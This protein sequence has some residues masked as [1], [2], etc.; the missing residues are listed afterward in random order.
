M[1]NTVTNEALHGS[2]LRKVT[3]AWVADSAGAASEALDIPRG[4]LRQFKFIPDSGGT[5]PD[6]SYDV[7]LNDS[8]SVDFLAGSG[9]NLSNSAASI[10][11]P[12]ALLIF[13]GEGQLTLAVTNAGAANGGTVILWFG[14]VEGR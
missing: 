2:N 5:Q 11:K 7:V 6:A 10:V 4:E 8:N 1:A 14:P 13:D 9:A 12:T 3:I